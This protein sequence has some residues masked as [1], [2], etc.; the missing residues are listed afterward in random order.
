MQ[1]STNEKIVL[2]AKKH[3]TMLLVP[4][5]LTLATGGLAIPWLIFRVIS[6]SCDEIII[7]DKSFHLKMVTLT[8]ISS[9][10]T[11]LEKINNFSYKQDL[12]D[13]LFNIGTITIQSAALNGAVSYSWV[14]N[15]ESIKTLL[16]ETTDKKTVKVELAGI[17]PLLQ[18]TS[19]RNLCPHCGKYYEGN[20]AFC[21]L[22]G[23]SV[24][25][26]KPVQVTQLSAASQE[27]TVTTPPEIL[28]KCDKC[29]NTIPD[30]YDKCFYCN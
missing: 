27:K 5:I 26:I 15:P 12:I 4:F 24:Q 25:A 7:T 14:Q 22:C 11:P 3:W 13:T 2:K 6:Y 20:A 21:P 10:S 9:I 29:G 8:S 1:L 30:G 28:R 18:T 23:Q 16:T 19:L 17:D